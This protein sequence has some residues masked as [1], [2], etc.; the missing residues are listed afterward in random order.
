[1]SR[2]SPK[3]P[4]P[5]GGGGGSRSGGLVSGARSGEGFPLSSA[6]SVARS[7]GGPCPMSAGGPLVPYL[8]G[9]VP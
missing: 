5:V 4:C 2:G 9:V 3:V 1:M 7:G 8:M 6:R